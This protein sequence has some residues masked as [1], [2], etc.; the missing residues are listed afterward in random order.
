[1]SRE[2]IYYAILFVA[3]L[4]LQALIC[5][6]IVLFNVAVPIIFIYFIISRFKK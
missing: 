6:H 2:L 5:N 4:L 3:M 1:M